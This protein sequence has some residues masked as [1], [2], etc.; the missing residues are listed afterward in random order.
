LEG[1]I[2]RPARRPGVRQT[3]EAGRI[4]LSAWQ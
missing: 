3:G 2:D 1:L 4:D